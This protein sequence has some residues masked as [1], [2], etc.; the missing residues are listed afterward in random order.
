VV[1]SRFCQIWDWPIRPSYIDILPL[2][3]QK[4]LV[5]IALSANIVSA[6]APVAEIA[7]VAEVVPVVK[8][9]QCLDKECVVDLIT[10]YSRRYGMK[11]SLAVRIAACESQFKTDAVGDNGK[12]YGVFQFHK[13]TFEEFSRKFGEELEYTNPEHNIKLAVWA[14][15]HGL[16]SH[17]TCYGKVTRAK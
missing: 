15:T 7:P 17:W 3:I 5:G 11:E 2:V 4:A 10:L 9:E 8:A 13:P 1:V 14:L 12:A 16:E 6:A